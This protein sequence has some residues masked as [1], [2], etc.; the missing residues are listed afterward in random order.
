MIFKVLEEYDWGSFAVITSLYPGYNI[1][2]DVIRSFTDASYFGWE[3]Q[4]VLTF[5]MT[6]D[7]SNSKTQRLLRQID[8]QV[9][10]VYCS[11]EEAEYL[12]QVAEEAGL[13]GPGYVWIVPSLTVGNMELPPVSFPIG[14]ISVVT[15]SWKMS[16]RQK[17]R[18][19]VAIIAMGASSYYRTSG[20]LPDVGKD[21]KTPP[22][23]VTNSTFYRSAQ[24]SYSQVAS[25]R[26]WHWQ[27]ARW[28][29]G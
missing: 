16:L 1:F 20:H 4:D 5:E 25:I 18:D 29:S 6:Q 9:M 7:G 12:F 8:A 24:E 23:T 17:V 2:L 21:C 14:L 15:E 27:L 10:I 3:L 28:G 22:S 19:G 13:I 11:R 26:V